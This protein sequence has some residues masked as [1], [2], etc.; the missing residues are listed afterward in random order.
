[1]AL[2]T[3]ATLKPCYDL[4]ELHLLGNPCT[5]WKGYRNYV[6]STLPQ[7]LSLDGEEITAAERA[8]AVADFP[9]LENELKTL[10]ENG[11]KQ[12]GSSSTVTKVD[13]EGEDKPHG[14]QPWL[15]E[16]RIQDQRQVS[17]IVNM[18]FH[19]IKRD[20]TYNGD[21]MLLQRV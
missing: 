4:R 20:L 7:L 14:L 1:M 13:F 18:L 6:I 8:Q 5:S 3:V 11:E 17:I 15:P 2:P 9:L 21:S 10:I 12:P 16:L 19:L